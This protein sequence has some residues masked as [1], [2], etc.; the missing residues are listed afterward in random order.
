MHQKPPF[1]ISGAAVMLTVPPK[2]PAGK[3]NDLPQKTFWCVCVCV[4]GGGG[5]GGSYGIFTNGKGG[6]TI[7]LLLP[8]GKEIKNLR[9]SLGRTLAIQSAVTWKLKL[10]KNK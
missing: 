1:A 6:T 3:A 9:K 7:F 8:R 2:P 4:W 5:G 10:S